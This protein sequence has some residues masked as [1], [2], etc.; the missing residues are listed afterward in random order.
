MAVLER[1][2]FRILVDD[3]VLPV[4]EPHNWK[5]YYTGK[6]VIY[7]CA[8]IG[9]KLQTLHRFLIDDHAII[10]E[11]PPGTV[12]DHINGDVLDNRRQNL[13]FATYSQNRVNSQKPRIANKVAP[14]SKYKGVM[15]KNGARGV[16]FHASIKVNRKARFLGAF[17]SE[18]D[19]AVAYDKAAVEV[20][21]EFARLNFPETAPH[22]VTSFATGW[23]TVTDSS[24]VNPQSAPPINSKA[25][26]LERPGDWTIDV[27]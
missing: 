21:G 24:D 26:G 8:Q 11:R 16:R 2:G 19:A 20:Y 25:S 23:S 18:K 5:F 22:S 27:S 9:K 14:T 1:N 3:D 7:L 6:P 4:V 15:R 12:A 13:R 17:I 10:G